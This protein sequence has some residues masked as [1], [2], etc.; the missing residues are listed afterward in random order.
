MVG[1]SSISHDDSIAF[2]NLLMGPSINADLTH[3][4]K[5]P[6][7][8]T[9]ELFD[10]I[11]WRF[12]DA[13]GDGVPDDEGCNSSSITT[14]TIVVGGID[15]GVP[16]TLFAGGCT[17]A[18]LIAEAKADALNHGG[19]VAA[20]AQLGNGWVASGLITGADGDIGPFF[21][22]SRM[23][24]RPCAAGGWLSWREPTA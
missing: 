8:L 11:G 12:P 23:A 15:T 4:V 16:N 17:S 13:D 1:G 19:Y 14:P 3:N 9:W 10:D 5:S 24:L 2:R 6:F 22:R 18:D 20:V 21:F 7:D